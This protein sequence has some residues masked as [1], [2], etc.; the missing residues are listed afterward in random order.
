MASTSASTSSS[1]LT[2]A[3]R[4]AHK[5]AVLRR[6]KAE[7]EARA[8]DQL[9]ELYEDTRDSIHFAVENQLRK[10]GWVK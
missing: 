4:K 1:A 9:I 6:W 2:K 5:K 3:E 7:Q 8:I 10:A